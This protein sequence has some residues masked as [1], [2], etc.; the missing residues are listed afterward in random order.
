MMTIRAA[1]FADGQRIVEMAQRFLA[2]TAYGELLEPTTAAIAT[3]VSTVL[4]AGVI[5]VA[6]A[7]GGLVGMIAL[8]ALVHPINGRRYAE[9]LT[10]WVEPEYRRSTIGPK[11]LGSAEDWARQNG[12]QGLKMVAP[13][14]S[15]IG[16]FY[17][18]RGYVLVE[19]AYHKSLM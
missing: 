17:E 13:A 6:E 14:N 3:L 5:F 19:S 8:V 18:R 11:L 9:E 1:T 16:T 12:C 15:S 2:V 4:E 7:D 10:W